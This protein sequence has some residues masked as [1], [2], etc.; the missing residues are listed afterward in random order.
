MQGREIRAAPDAKRGLALDRLCQLMQRT[1]WARGYVRDSGCRRAR[2]RSAGLA[3]SWASA[4]PRPPMR[5]NEATPT[6]PPTTH[7][8]EYPRYAT[9]RA[10][11]ISI[12]QTRAADHR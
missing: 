5:A 10:L 3:W 4:Y 6:I 7:H 2:A 1:T 11:V 8:P 12:S 9:L